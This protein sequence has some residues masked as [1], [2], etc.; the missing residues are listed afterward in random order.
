MARTRDK[1]IHDYGGV[2]PRLV[3]DTVEK[4]LAALRDQVARMLE[5]H[6]S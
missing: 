5:A 1:L 3:W 2:N 6:G 4:H